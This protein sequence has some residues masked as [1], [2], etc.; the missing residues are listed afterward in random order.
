[1]SVKTTPHNRE[2]ELLT[3]FGPRVMKYQR[4]V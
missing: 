3:L 1:M 2:E 4:T